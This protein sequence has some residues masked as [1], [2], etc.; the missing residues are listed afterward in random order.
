M[1]TP[2]L[3]ARKLFRRFG[4]RVVLRGVNLA[5][6]PGEFVALLGPNGA[7][8]T[9]LLRIFATLLRPNHGY[10]AVYG[11][12]LPQN[13]PAAR[14]HL[15]FISHQPLL[16]PDLS[17][18]QNLYFFGRLYRVP[19]L[20][21]RIASLL[22]MVGLYRRRRDPVRTYSRGMQQRLAIA[23]ALLHDPKVLLLDE[24]YTGLDQDAAQRLDELLQ[25][26]ASQGRSVL[27]TSHD[28]GRVLDL[29]HRF[30]V[31]TQGRIVASARREDI[32]AH[33]G[34]LTFYRE[35]LARAAR[36]PSGGK[37]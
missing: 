5:V 32:D 24:P 36:T 27:M 13:A 19:E 12:R 10:V 6:Q 37:A 23:R 31:L 2:V 20:A 8:K 18:E 28:L 26:I 3:E 4:S 14:R 22:R 29:A 21:D 25:L 1:S 33:G 34:L 7:G 16:Y 11:H 30:V 15:G 35:A 9:T 17:A